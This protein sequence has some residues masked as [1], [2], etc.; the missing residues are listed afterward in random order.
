MYSLLTCCA[1]LLNG[2]VTRDSRR[3]SGAA[4][5]VGTYPMLDTRV[6]FNR[7]TINNTIY[8]SQSCVNSGFIPYDLDSV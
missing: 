5:P 4:V 1:A 7:C 8:P 2:F 6:S 3:L